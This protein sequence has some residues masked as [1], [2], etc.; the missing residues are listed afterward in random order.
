MIQWLYDIPSD[1]VTDLE[2]YLHHTIEEK[3]RK[4]YEEEL[5]KKKNLARVEADFNQKRQLIWLGIG[6]W[7]VHLV[8]SDKLLPESYKQWSNVIAQAF[9][10]LA[11]LYRTY[12]IDH[13]SRYSVSRDWT[14]VSSI[15]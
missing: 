9:P 13:N 8:S 3:L 5:S 1:R 4:D 2:H 12:L 11:I 6:G 14:S 15:I 10:D 7:L